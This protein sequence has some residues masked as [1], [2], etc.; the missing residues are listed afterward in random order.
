MKSSAPG[1]FS[2][3]AC[4]C[5]FSILMSVLSS[6]GNIPTITVPETIPTGDVTS[7]TTLF[8]DNCATC[9]G[10]DGAGDDVYP[11]VNDGLTSETIQLTVRLGGGAMPSFSQSAISSQDLGDIIAFIET[12]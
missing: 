8:V 6:C 1:S 3:V 10:T 4:V 5:G 11:A 2:I 12:L 7:G 9:H